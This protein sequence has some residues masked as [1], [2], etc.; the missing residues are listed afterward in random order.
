MVRFTKNEY[1]F[2]LI[3]L[4]QQMNQEYFFPPEILLQ[5]FL[6]LAPKD[7][8]SCRLA[9][10]T[11]R[12]LIAQFP[13]L[14]YHR[15]DLYGPIQVVGS[16]GSGKLYNATAMRVDQETSNLLVCDTSGGRI[17][18]F[19]TYGKYIS[20]FSPDSTSRPCGICIFGSRIW[21][22]FHSESLEF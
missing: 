3:T 20:T 14:D 1:I 19:S 8:R 10:S 16:I 4:F 21:V 7:L 22:T 18:T 13:E 12:D 2:F 15:L 17:Q 5:I 11:F 6:N 9:S